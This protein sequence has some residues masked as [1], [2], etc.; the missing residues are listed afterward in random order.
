[1]MANT[2]FFATA[3]IIVSLAG[4]ATATSAPLSKL[5]RIESQLGCKAMASAGASEGPLKITA[6]L[7]AKSDKTETD[8][9]FW[10]QRS[11]DDFLLVFTRDGKLFHP[12]CA[13]IIHWKWYP[14]GLEIISEKIPLTEFVFLDDFLKWNE[15]FRQGGVTATPRRGPESEHTSAIIKDGTSFE[16]YFYCYKGSWLI[17]QRD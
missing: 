9:L 10:C 17:E 12:E 2:K 3:V 6:D 14:R 15:S 4:L 11:Q 16:T 13:P 8:I 7:S 1:M 5:D